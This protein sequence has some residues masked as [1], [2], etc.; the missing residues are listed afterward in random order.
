MKKEYPEE[1]E[2]VL[3][4]VK[5]IKKPQVFVIIDK[6]NK[7]GVIQFSEVSP[8]RIRNIRKYVVPN[9]KIVCKVLRVFRETGHID[10]SLRRVSSKE[11][12][13]MMERYSL[14]KKSESLLAAIF[15]EKFSDYRK[16]ILEKFEDLYEFILEVE[17]NGDR[18][19]GI[20]IEKKYI[21]EIIEEVKRRFQKKEVEKKYSLFLKTYLSDGLYIIINLLKK[22]EDKA[23]VKVK[24]ISAPEYCIEI[25]GK[26]YNE[27]ANKYKDIERIIRSHKKYFDTIEI[28]EFD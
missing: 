9:K 12:K 7:L 16:K 13:E 24:Y 22:I 18:L 25:K 26:D 21:K 1:G 23:G 20:N 2:I 27:I 6:Y 14:N 5:E 4:T 17:K 8:G 15:K 19:K 11:K 28:K 3:C 10:L